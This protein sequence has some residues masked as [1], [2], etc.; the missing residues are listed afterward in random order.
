MV[1][2]MANS[3]ASTVSLGVSHEPLLG[4]DD[5][6]GGTEVKVTGVSPSPQGAPVLLEVPTMQGHHVYVLPQDTPGSRQLMTKRGTGAWAPAPPSATRCCLSSSWRC[7]YSWGK[8]LCSTAF[9]VTVTG[10]SRPTC[11]SVR[12]SGHLHAWGQAQSRVWAFSD[13]AWWLSVQMCWGSIAF[14][15]SVSAGKGG[16]LTQYL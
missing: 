5:D 1:L 11:S 3:M 9:R 7:A 10:S 16:W 2:C 6:R 4:L 14:M 13:S 8:L 15:H 12:H